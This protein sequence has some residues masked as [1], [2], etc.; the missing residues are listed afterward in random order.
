VG[1]PSGANGNGYD[2]GQG[3]PVMA[4]ARSV[5][6]GPG[7]PGMAT[8]GGSSEPIVRHIPR[9]SP[10][11]GGEVVGTIEVVIGGRARGVA[12]AV[13]RPRAAR[14]PLPAEPLSESPDPAA[15]HALAPEHEEEPP[16]SDEARREAAARD[17]SPTRPLQAL[18]GQRLHV[19]FRPLGGDTLGSAFETLRELLHA[20][21]GETPVV[22][23][24]PAGS[25]EQTMELRTGVAYDAELLADIDRRLPGLARVDLS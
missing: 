7:S 25:Q 13:S 24:I 22:L 19:H 11:R 17:A 3:L 20:H 23:H 14:V 16:L 18:P 2:R 6:V 5:A 15:L 4:E 10:L 8:A 1:A 9:V 12:A 21:V